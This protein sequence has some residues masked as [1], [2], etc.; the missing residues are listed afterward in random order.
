MQAEWDTYFDELEK[1][2]EPIVFV[3]IEGQEVITQTFS[4]QNKHG[5]AQFFS[6]ANVDE[7]LIQFENIPY[8]TDY[9]ESST[10]DK[11]DFNKLEIDEDILYIRADDMM[12]EIILEE[13]D[14]T[15][16]MTVY[17]KFDSEGDALLEEVHQM[18][19]ED[20]VEE[21]VVDHRAEILEHA[22]LFSLEDLDVK[23]VTVLVDADYTGV[24]LE[25][26]EEEVAIIAT[27]RN[28]ES[29]F[30][31]EE[32]LFV[33]S[34]VSYEGIDI[35][36]YELEQADDGKLVQKGYQTMVDDMYYTFAIEQPLD[37]FDEKIIFEKIAQIHGK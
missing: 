19:D 9:W 30:H 18:L 35:D 1:Q 5:N 34:E 36:K 20:I 27:I 28:A 4:Y 21:T 37:N 17:G 3:N 16:E 23:R 15:Y 10:N 7:T 24:E 6:L 14:H 2:M 29:D 11:E 26:D 31:H 12:S 33:K 8:L 25:Y 13:D 32:D 22:N